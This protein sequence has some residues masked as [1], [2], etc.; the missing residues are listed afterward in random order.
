M[1]IGHCTWVSGDGVDFVMRDSE[2]FDFVIS[3]RNEI[4]RYTLVI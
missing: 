3:R 2:Q 4:S 1:K